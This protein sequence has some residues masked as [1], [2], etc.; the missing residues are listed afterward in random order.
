MRGTY[1]T[2]S[3]EII[4]EEIKSFSNGFTIKELKTSLDN[5]NI[6]VGLTTLY[7][8]LLDLENKNIVK[9]YFDDNNV[10]HFK[11]IISSESDNVFYLKCSKC[12]KIVP[13]DCEC[14]NDFYKHI[15]GKHKFYIEAKNIILS[16]L[17]N[18]CKNFI[19][20]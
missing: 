1:K 7:R 2:K 19:K 6:N 13:V 10:A 9:K 12:E 20:L 18:D 8:H 14:I 5:K 16:G 15:L 4:N 17:C 3:K 11:T